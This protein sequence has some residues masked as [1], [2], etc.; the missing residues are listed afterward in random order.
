MEDEGQQIGDINILHKRI[1]IFNQQSKQIIL[2]RNVL[3]S[4]K[5]L[6]KSENFLFLNRH[7]Y[8]DYLCFLLTIGWLRYWVIGVLLSWRKLSAGLDSQHDWSSF[9][10]SPEA[11][12][13]TNPSQN[14][15]SV[16]QFQNNFENFFLL[17]SDSEDTQ[18][19]TVQIL[20][21]NFR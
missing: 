10:Q 1:E 15:F 4:Q 21:Q 16:P 12:W 13:E 11:R 20:L 9:K 14:I 7:K 6:D 3:F 19:T 8:L 18:E 5:D 2:I 17:D